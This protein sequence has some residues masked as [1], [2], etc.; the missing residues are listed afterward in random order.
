MRV[1]R[2][3]CRVLI[4]YQLLCVTSIVLSGGDRCC[5]ESKVAHTFLI[6]DVRKA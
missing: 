2:L 1:F 4:Y 5:G 6:V 3:V